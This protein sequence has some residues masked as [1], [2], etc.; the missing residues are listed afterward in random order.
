MTHRRQADTAGR[1]DLRQDPAQA[2]GD[3]G[4]L[5]SRCARLLTAESS[6]PSPDAS[7]GHARASP[8]NSS[9]AATRLC[10]QG[11]VRGMRCRLAAAGA[12]GADWL[13]PAAPA[14]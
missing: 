8:R 10:P 9:P 2:T 14:A 11:C 1:V 13:P 7:G 12:C 3:R 6:P 5:S 4:T